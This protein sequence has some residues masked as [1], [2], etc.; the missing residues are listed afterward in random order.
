MAIAGGTAAGTT[1]AD[2]RARA[3][4]GIRAL[5]RWY[6]WW[7][8][9]WRTTGWW[10]AANAL[11]T[12]VRYTQTTGDRSH[13]RVIN[14]SFHVAPRSH[15]RFINKFYDDMAWWALA[16]LDAYD[17]TGKRHYARAAEIIFDQM[18]TGWDDHCRGGLWWNTDRKYKNAIANEL[19]LSVAARLH[20]TGQKDGSRFL[21][22]ALKEWDW[23]NASGMI[24]ESGLINDG[25]TADCQNNGQPCYTYNQGVVLGGLSALYEITGD[26]GYLHAGE[27]IADAAIKNLVSPPSSDVPGILVDPGDEA[28]ATARSRGD[29][30]QFKG[31]FIR[32]LHDFSGHSDRPAYRDFILR[33][34]DSVWENSRDSSD[35]LGLRWTGPFDVADA[36]RQSSALDVL[37]AAAA[38]S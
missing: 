18:T 1:G 22:W 9:Q 32:N 13:L 20:R 16:W 7:T 4:T 38:L 30:S 19:F 14:W 29:G 6:A 21:D 36:S 17:L 3:Q 25:L 12:I 8:G 27:T 28:M 2:R 34:A 31:I 33:N 26:K 37:I 10:N 15:P 5:Q 11:T 23:F 35:H 24:G